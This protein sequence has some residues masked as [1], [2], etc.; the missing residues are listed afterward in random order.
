MMLRVDIKTS[1]SEETFV[2]PDWDKERATNFYGNKFGSIEE[3]VD[4]YF[5]GMM[6]FCDDFEIV[7]L[8][9]ATETDIEEAKQ[10]AEDNW[11]E[12]FDFELV[13]VMAAA[14]KRFMER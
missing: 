1:Y 5:F 7:K 6:C 13:G 12:D 3:Y 14:H 9:T 8:K 10:R 2:I 4:F 11:N